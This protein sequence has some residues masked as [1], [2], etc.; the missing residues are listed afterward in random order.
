MGRYSYS[1]LLKK[2]ERLGNQHAR[3]ANQKSARESVGAH[4]ARVERLRSAHRECSA[5]VDWGAMA[6]TLP[7]PSVALMFEKTAAARRR[8]ALEPLGVAE[9]LPEVNAAGALDLRL[10]REAEKHHAAELE[11]QTRGAA[12]ARAILREEK[13]AFREVLSDQVFGGI[14]EDGA[15]QVDFE[16]HSPQLVEARIEVQP[17]NIVP[18][19]I[20]SLTSTGKLSTK[21]MPRLQFVEL[22][23]DYVC[24]VVLRVAREVHALLPIQATLITAFS[25]D[26]LPSRSP[27]LSTVIRRTDL[28]RLSFD[29]LDPSDALDSLETRTNFKASRRTGAFQPVVAFVANEVRLTANEASLASTTELARQFLEE[30][31]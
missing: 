30:V 29:S 26:G 6:A 24:S 19:E 18:S 1:S 17:S 5:T 20:Q 28:A 25:T 27:V 3:D 7:P 14:A 23:Q 10:L 2:Q 12:L 16:V 13:A 21:S 15:L 31:E 9:G 4:Q 11:E 22:Y 8:A